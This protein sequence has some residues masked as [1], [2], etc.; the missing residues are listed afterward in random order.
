MFLE[1]M[2]DAVET[3]FYVARQRH[4]W[5]VERNRIVQSGHADRDTAIQRALM[6]ADAARARGEPV[7]VRIQEDA[8]RWREARSFAPKG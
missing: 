5:S 4:G 6:A 8:G 7:A 1:N 2:E 3:I